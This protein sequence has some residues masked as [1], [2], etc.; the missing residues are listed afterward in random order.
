M[1][2]EIVALEANQIWTLAKLPPN[3]TTIHCKWVYR[4]SHNTTLMVLLSDIKPF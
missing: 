4:L 1:A 3:K 2:A